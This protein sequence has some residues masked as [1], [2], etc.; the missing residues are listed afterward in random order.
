MISFEPTEDQQLV[1]DTVA[2]FAREQIRPAAREADESGHIPE[3]LIQQ[4][5]ELGLVQNAI[6]EAFGGY[7]DQ[8]LAI[9]SSLSV[10]CQGCAGP[11]SPPRAALRVA[12]SRRERRWRIRK[13]ALIKVTAISTGRPAEMRIKK[14]KDCSM[15][16]SNMT[17]LLSGKMARL[18]G[19]CLS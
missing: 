7:G 16:L 4:A 13:A 10:A 3:T 14:G 1:R 19:G 8:R 6:P 11:I 15:K 2:S 17:L 18:A 12:S 5:W 9:Q